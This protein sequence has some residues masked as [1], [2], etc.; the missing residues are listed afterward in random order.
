[1][2]RRPF[3]AFVLLMTS[4][5]YAD[6]QSQFRETYTALSS[7]SCALVAERMGARLKQAGFAQSEVVFF[8]D[9]AHPKEGGLVAIYPGTDKK[10]KA[11]LLLAHVDVMEAKRDGWAGDP[12]ALV[13]DNGH[14][15]ARGAPDNTAQAAIWVD[16]LVRYRQEQLK[17]RRT[18]KLAL[19]CGEEPA[20]GFNGAKWLGENRRDLIDA[21]FALNEGAI[22]ELDAQGNRVT[23]PVQVGEKLGVSYQL[24]VT[25]RGGDSSLPVR[26]NAIYQLAGVLKKIEAYEFPAQFT[27]ASLAYFA[28]MAKIQAAKGNGEVADAMSALVK[29]PSDAQAIT[30]VSAKDPSWNATL[31]TTCATTMLEGGHDSNALPQRARAIINCRIFPGVSVESVRH[32]LE[33]L[34]A[35]PAVKVSVLE[36]RSTPASTPPLTP[37]ILGPVQKLAAKAFPGVPVLPFLQAGATETDG[38]FLNA[39]GIP[40]YSVGAIFARPDVGDNQ[41]LNEYVSVRSLLEG[42]EFLYQ[43]VKVYAKAASK[44][45]D[46]TL[47]RNHHGV[48]AIVRPK[49][50]QDAFQMRFDGAQRDL[51]VAGYQLVRK[52]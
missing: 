48:R 4:A 51:Q 33:D 31:R 34:V 11:L 47:K 12:F 40:T 22:G 19:T 20:G 44:I 49:L 35:D 5:A 24:E 3:L 7:G 16:T 45:Q 41:G 30:F 29:N 36:I 17:A 50:R 26:E 27:D 2:C 14:Y 39:V 18:L 42:R 37:Q 15:Y 10:A 13:E 38:V 9:P 8:A 28:G 21:A 52:P 32:K 25:N 6:S 23:L 43:L 46:P 1:M